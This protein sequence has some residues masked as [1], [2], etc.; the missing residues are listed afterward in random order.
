MVSRADTPSPL[1]NP[2]SRL[3]LSFIFFIC[4]VF[5]PA[6]PLSPYYF[7]ISKRTLGKRLSR[8]T[9]A[10]KSLLCQHKQKFSGSL[11][12][13]FS[14]SL[15]F[16]GQSNRQFKFFK[17]THISVSSTTFNMVVYAIS[18]PLQKSTSN[19]L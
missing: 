11:N 1:G 4:P 14:I 15:S 12:Q 7:S 19:C 8:P 5:N 13:L 2:A 10:L 3:K 9:V 18:S 16:K 6:L 17:K